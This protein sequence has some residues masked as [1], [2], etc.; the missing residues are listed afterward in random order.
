MKTRVLTLALLAG[1][2]L[3]ANAQITTP[4]ASPAATVA[5]TVGLT[6]MTIDYSRPSLKGR[7]MFG[8]QVPYGKVWRTGADQSTKLTLTDA[9]TLGGKTVP[10][11]S[12]G[13][14]TIPDKTE[15]TV[16]LSKDTKGFGA[17]DYKPE[18]D[19][20]RFT[21]KPETVP[22]TEFFTIE[23]TDFTPTSANLT[24]RWETTQLKIPVVSN[25]D[26]RI[27]AQIKEQTA[28][29]NVKPGVYYAAAD[30]YWQTNR[31]LKQALDWANKVVANEQ[32]YWT[33]YLRAKIEQKMG[34][35]PTAKTDAKL[36]LDMAKKA[37]YDAY[38]KNNERL[39]AECN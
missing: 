34:S 22:S 4:A 32:Q 26:E 7:K 5:Q 25:P 14:F 24:L 27:M 2:V 8:D 18:N 9:V 21:M 35:C 13:L 3:N 31:D 6:K 23:F 1:T 12:Y 29:T 15:W 33:Y 16:I 20:L 38:V 28:G 30:Y 37:G 10:A 11:G 39:L 17:F 19:L 36:S